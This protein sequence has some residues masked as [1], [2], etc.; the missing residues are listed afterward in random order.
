MNSLLPIAYTPAYIPRMTIAN[1]LDQ[2]MQAAGFPSQSAL[3]R[4]S[5][6]PQPTINRILKNAGKK[7]PEA[8]T[9]KLLAEACNVNFTW[10][11]EGTGPMKRGE[12]EA[13]A[14]GEVIKVSIPEDD[15]GEF[16][17]VRMVTRFIH[18]GVPGQDGDVEYED[19]VR[20]SLRRAWIV[21][22]KL[23]PTALVA[24]RV[25]GDSMVPTLRKGNI[26]IVDTA[27]RDKSRLVDGKL[28]A[29]N[30]QG[31][32]VVKRMENQG[33]RWYL[34][35]DNPDKEYGPRPVDETTEIIGRV[36]RMEADFI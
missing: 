7:G 21:E 13:Q 36:V 3:A 6:V 1:R 28:Y 10:L 20:L 19:E 24:I 15:E 33:G 31:K 25:T 29:V 12:Q 35:S 23:T 17:G 9:I 2:A 4:A 22:K 18:A 27:E 32:P 11:Y 30:H 8:H 14:E 16:V 26:V 5:E 34:T